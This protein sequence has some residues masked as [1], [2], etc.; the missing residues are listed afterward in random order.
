M[1]AHGSGGNIA[2]DTGT[3]GVPVVRSPLDVAL[4]ALQPSF[5]IITPATLWGMSRAERVE[6]ALARNIYVPTLAEERGVPDVNLWGRA[7]R[8]D[9]LPNALVDVPESA[10]ALTRAVGDCPDEPAYVEIE[11]DAGVP[12]RANGIEMPLIELIESLE[13]IGG[14]HGVGRALM[15]SSPTTDA[16]VMYEAPAAFVLHTAHR[17]LERRVLPKDLDRVKEGLSRLY[18]DAVFEGRWFSATREAID[19]FVR[20]LQPRVTGSVRLQLLKGECR[21]VE[22]LEGAIAEGLVS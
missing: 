6:Y 7:F 20:A 12:V 10:Y 1:L 9:S 14:A 8:C 11:F 3:D 22:A 18:S 15:P 5:T 19:G 13:I 2:G 4:H 16:A 21:V 17:E